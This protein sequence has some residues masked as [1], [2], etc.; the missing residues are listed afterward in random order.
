[1]ATL[2]DTGSLV[3]IDGVIWVEGADGSLLQALA[4]D[5][6]LSAVG[7]RQAGLAETGDVTG[8]TTAAKACLLVPAGAVDHVAEGLAVQVPPEVV[9]EQPPEGPGHVRLAAGRDVRCQQDLG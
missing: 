3:R 8:L 6:S 2:T 5:G 1:M 4:V 7:R 9:G